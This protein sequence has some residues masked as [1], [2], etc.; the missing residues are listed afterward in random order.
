MKHTF[1]VTIALFICL[2]AFS[3]QKKEWNAQ[4]KVEANIYSPRTSFISY[5]NI[6]NA[7]ADDY[8]LAR[9]TIDLNGDWEFLRLK[10]NE[11]TKITKLI[12][13][14]ASFGSW[15]NVT[16]P[17][18]WLSKSDT[19]I[20]EDQEE[21]GI[22]KKKAI[23]PSNWMDKDV[24]FI[25]GEAKSAAHLYVNGKKIG[26]NENSK[27]SA[28]YNIT[29]YLNIGSNEII[30]VLYSV[31]DGLLFEPEKEHNQTG[32]FG[33]TYIMAQPK[34]RI[35][36]FLIK[37]SSDK[38]YK[39]GLFDIL[40]EVSNSYKQEQAVLVGYDII[41]ENGDIVTYNNRKVIVASGASD[42]IHM[43]N[44]IDNAKIWSAETPNLYTILFRVAINGRYVEY[45]TTNFGFRNIE[46]I[47]K[48]LNINGKPLKIK[49]INY[50]GNIISED[51]LR[52]ELSLM[53]QSGIN[54]IK[55]SN[56]PQ[57]SMFYKLCDKY[58]FYVFDEANINTKQTDLLN[59]LENNPKWNSV[60]LTRI[61]NM[62]QRNKNST[63]IIAWSL[64][65]GLGNGYN[66]YKTYQYLKKADTIRPILYHGAGREWNSDFYSPRA[67]L[68]DSVAEHELLD[69]FRP[70][71][72]S[73]FTGT[74]DLFRKTWLQVTN[75]DAFQGGFMIN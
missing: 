44:I 36:D 30:I 63:C 53:K 45:F 2:V 37:A 25:L 38:E 48:Q 73:D 35:N 13:D 39:N 10:N 20:V 23:I 62:Y 42:T 1:A 16:I 51:S 27:F 52:N 21:I 68:Y 60:Y 55:T 67:S 15:E 29:N 28:E 7:F 59:S 64:G 54:A 5:S 9:N 72:F 65:S 3:Q 58:G 14:E 19:S 4:N 49:G 46:I 8:R 17:S 34:I 31:S 69:K 61:K 26:H 24:F 74:N 70:T 12:T 41:N 56:N 11:S 33:N 75:N 6:E 32:I 18:E 22:Y 47:D 43:S 50:N 40:I 66:Q 57:P 71:I